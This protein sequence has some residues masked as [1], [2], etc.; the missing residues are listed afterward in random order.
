MANYNKGTETRDAI[1]RSAR[2]LFYGSGYL[3]THNKDIAA[4]A[5]VN[6]GLIHYY[7]RTK[8]AMALE[9][10]MDLLLTQLALVR[11]HF[12][13]EDL[14]VRNAIA[15]R[16]LWDMMQQDTALLRF[17]HEI[18]AERIPLQMADSSVGQHYIEGLNA[19]GGWLNEERLQII[20]RCSIA[21]EMELIEHYASGSCAFS[22]EELA[23]LDERL[24]LQMVSVPEREILRVLQ[25]S[26]ECAAPYC[27]EMY[28]PFAIRLRRREAGAE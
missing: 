10:Y 27:M 15:I 2:E 28:A 3:D 16:F 7:Y 8:G 24:T 11:E 22:A 18:N 23:E 4:H 5:G 9:I 6:V 1:L 12:P 19:G 25:R 26:R 14:A 17:M 20:C 21:A 13:E